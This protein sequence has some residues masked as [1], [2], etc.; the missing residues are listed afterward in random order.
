MIKEENK[1]YFSSSGGEG[2]WL[3][4]VQGLHPPMIREAV[5]RP[6]QWLR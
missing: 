3:Q 2:G 1:I 4:A 6:I 5:M